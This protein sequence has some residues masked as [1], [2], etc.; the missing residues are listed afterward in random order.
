MSKPAKEP[1]G[2][3]GPKGK[4]DRRPWPKPSEGQPATKAR[5]GKIREKTK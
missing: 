2:K 4:P 5:N 1:D 3:P